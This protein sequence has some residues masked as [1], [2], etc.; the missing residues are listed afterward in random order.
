MIPNILL[1]KLIRFLFLFLCF[2]WCI[3]V[4]HCRNFHCDILE[5]V[6]LKEYEELKFLFHYLFAERE[7][8]YTLLGDKPL[9]FCLAP[10][11]SVAFST[12][13]HFFKIFYKNRID[14]R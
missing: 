12:K 11:C 9:S 14:L 8:G 3:P 10:T 13:E 7:F 4:V 5:E 6:S 1:K 2:S